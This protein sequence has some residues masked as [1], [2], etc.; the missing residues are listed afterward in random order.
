MFTSGQRVK[1]VGKAEELTGAAGFVSQVLDHGEEWDNHRFGRYTY[2]VRFGKSSK[3]VTAKE[4]EAM[5]KASTTYVTHPDGTRSQRKSATMAYTHAVEVRED[6]WIEAKR[7]HALATA[8]RE[9]LARYITAVRAG[10]VRT[11]DGGST[12]VVGEG[13]ETFYIGHHS[14]AQPLDRKASVRDRLADYKERA[15]KAEAE[16]REAESGPQYRYGVMRWSQSRANA[17]KGLLEF[18]R[19]YANR[20][21]HRFSVV[22]VDA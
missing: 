19:G 5:P 15:A 9:Y 12:Y 3:S 10:R 4:L 2:V 16:A 20:P 1:Y 17:N 14:E 7:L 11:E 18:E 8:R 22:E 6:M 21:S 13:D